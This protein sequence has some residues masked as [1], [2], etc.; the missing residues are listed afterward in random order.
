MQ[1]TMQMKILYCIIHTIAQKEREDFILSTWGRNK[2]LVFYGDYET[3]GNKYLLK[4]SD[5]SDYTSGEEKQINAISTFPKTHNNYN[6]Y[7]FCDNDTFVNTKLLEEFSQDCDQNKIYGEIANTWPKDP[8][9]SYPVGGAGFLVSNK[10]LN[11]LS[12]KVFHNSVNWGDVSL[13]LNLR[14]FKIEKTSREDLFHS[15]TPEFYGIQDT[16]IKN[17]ISFHY[18]KNYETMA[19]LNELCK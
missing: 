9:L 7:Y 15:Q 4:V 10:I 11:F 6:W 5:N 3:T 8:S 13:G 16:E 12:N 17:H 18:I 2:D 14:H 1:G 19:K